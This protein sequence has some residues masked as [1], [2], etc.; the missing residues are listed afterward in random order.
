MR[1]DTKSNNNNVLIARLNDVAYKVAHKKVY[2]RS[3]MKAP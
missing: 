1:A 2:R 3:L